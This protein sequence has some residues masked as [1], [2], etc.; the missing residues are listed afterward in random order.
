VIRDL[1]ESDI[2]ILREIHS[3]TG[4]G[5]D[6]PDFSAMVNALV[7]EE[8]G[9]VVG[10]AGA[11]VEAQIFGIFDQSWGTPGERMKIFAQLHKPI[12]E[13]LA[14]VGVKEAYVAVDPQFPAFGRRLMSLGWRKALWVHY[15]LP[16]KD[17]LARFSGKQAA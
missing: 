6:F 12:A 3:R 1:R 14:S 4:Y 7:I 11:Q 2:E 13:K 15:F 8:E 9:R 5:F 17:C 10:F 16:V